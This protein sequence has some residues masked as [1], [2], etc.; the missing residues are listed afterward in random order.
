MKISE[1]A[2]KTGL[3]IST[4]RFYERKGLISPARAEGSTYRDYTEEDVNR[5]R[6]I[7]LYRKMNLSIESIGQLILD[8]ADLQ[9]VLRVQEQALETEREHL[10]GALDLCRKMLQDQADAPVDLDYYMNYVKTEEEQGRKYPE[11]IDA[12]DDLAEYSGV[13]RYFGYPAAFYLLS[14]TWPRRLTGA[15]VILV[16]VVFPLILLVSSI[17]KWN[18]GE[19]QTRVLVGSIL[20]AIL[21]WCAFADIVRRLVKNR[22]DQG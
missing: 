19:A 17:L 18:S 6:Q 16:L 7:I 12:L 21:L 3:D 5:L 11:I 14:H 4:I 2:D 8:H 15:A 22:R 13:E 9:T 10:E 20:I 1:V